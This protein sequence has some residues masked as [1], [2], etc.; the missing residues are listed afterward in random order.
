MTEDWTERQR[1]FEQRALRGDKPFPMESVKALHEA[2]Q[3]S[4][5]NIFDKQ[6]ELHVPGGASEAEVRAAMIHHHIQ[7][8]P[9]G[10]Q[11]LDL[12]TKSPQAQKPLTI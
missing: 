11:P 3:R 1:H 8:N 10:P 7:L 5:G 9:K 2:R 6:V 4:T 12:N